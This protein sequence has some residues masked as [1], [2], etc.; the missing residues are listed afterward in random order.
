MHNILE[1]YHL[2]ADIID[3]K[4]FF[5]SILVDIGYLI[6]MLIS[7]IFPFELHLLKLSFVPNDALVS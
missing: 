5:L 7:A 6:V 3:L 4:I 2:S 1:P